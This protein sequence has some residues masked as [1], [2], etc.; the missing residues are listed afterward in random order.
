MSVP[1]TRDEFRDYCLRKLG[2]DVLEINASEEQLEDRIDEALALYHEQHF[3]AVERV[4]Y[5]HQLTAGDVANTS[6]TLPSNIYGVRKIFSIGSLTPGVNSDPLSFNFQLR[7]SDVFNVA[8]GTMF[9]N[10]LIDY[11][12]YKRHTTLIE[13][14]FNGQTPIRFSRHMHILKIDGDWTNV[15]RSGVWIVADCT[16]FLDPDTYPSIWSDRWLQNYCTA[17]FMQQWGSNLSK[18]TEVRLPGGVTFNGPGLVAKAEEK[19]EALEVE[20]RNTFS[21]P[22]TMFIG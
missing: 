9:N 10:S 22:P 15:L 1:T 21:E 17:L 19:I 4:Y 2:Q 13:E 14:M 18:Y 11:Y 20:L 5:Q 6:I 3:D 16:R 12:L 8:S 7:A